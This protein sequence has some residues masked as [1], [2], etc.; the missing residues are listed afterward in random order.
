MIHL[1]PSLRRRRLSLAI[2][3]ST[4]AWV[5][6]SPPAAN[7]QCAPDP[8]TANGTTT[9]A[10]A[11]TDGLVVATPGTQVTV[12]SGATVAP[13]SAAAISIRSTNVQLTVNGA[14]DGV[15]KPGIAVIAGA[16]FT[17]PCDPYAGAG[18]GYCTPG[19]TT[20]YYPSA[21][22]TISVAEGGSV[23]GSQALLVSR[24][25]SNSLGYLSVSVTNAGTMTSASGPAIVATG[26]SSSDLPYLY[27]SN[28]ATGSIGGI[29]GAVS[30]VGNAG[31]ID[32]GSGAAIAGS[33]IFG[34]SVSNT[35][36]IR[37]SGSAATVSSAA[38]LLVTNASGATLG[39]SA[40]A[41]QADGYISLVNAG[42]IIGSVVSNVT[43]GYVSTIDTREGVIDGDVI[44]GAGNDTLRARF[45]AASGRVAS[46]TGTIDGGDGTDTLTIGI[47][48]DATVSRA[49]LPTNFELFGM[50]LAN[51]ATVTL[52]PGFT[53]GVGASFSGHG[54]VINQANL[55]TGGPAVVGTASFSPLSFINDGTIT[56]TLASD[57]EVAVSGLTN[58]TN[59]GT[60]TAIGG[61]GARVGSSL[62][63]NGTITAS[64]IAV[65]TASGSLTNTGTIR[66]TGSTGASISSA[67]ST[68]DGSIIGATTGVDLG[69]GTLVNNGT[70]SGGTTGVALSYSSS[71]TNNAGGTITGGVR[72]A[73][74][75]ARVTNAGTIDGSVEL[76]TNGSFDSSDDVFVD[77][78]GTVLGAI[79]LG[80][81]YDRLVV[82]LVSQE[83]RPLAGATGGVDGGDGFD[84]VHYRVNADASAALALVSGFEWLAYELDN[85]AALT[86]TAA[87]PITM[88]LGLTGNG[89]VTLAGTLS[90]SDRTLVD[91]TILTAAQLTGGG[92][93]P[94]QALSIVNNGTLNLSTAGPYGSNAVA[95][96]N[97]GTADVTNNGT[98]AVTNAAGIYYPAS[99]IFNG[100]AVT[101]TGAITLSG[102]GTAIN[103]ARTLVNSGTITGVAG[104]DIIG[105]FN[106]GSLDNSGTIQVDGTAVQMAYAPGDIVNSG[107]IESRQGTAVGLSYASVLTNEAGGTIRGVT[108][109]GLT[110]GGSVVNRGAIIGDIAANAYSYSGASYIADGGTLT[111]NLTFGSGSDLFLTTGAENGVSGTI[112]GGSGLDAFGRVLTSSGAVALGDDARAVNFEAM[113]IHASGADTVV[114]ITGGGQVTGSL[115]LSGDGTIINTATIDGAVSATQP[116]AARLVLPFYNGIAAFDNQGSIA[117][118]ISGGISDFTNSG[119]L[120][121]AALESAAVQLGGPGSLDFTNG[122][123]IRNAGSVPTVRLDTFRGYAITASNSGTIEGGGLSAGI[124]EFFGVELPSTPSTIALTNSGGIST[125][126]DGATAVNLRVATIYGAGMSLTLNNSGTL[127]AS[128]PAGGGAFLQAYNYSGQGASGTITVANSGTIRANGG[129]VVDSVFTWPTTPPY[130]HTIEIP[131]T[132]PAIALGVAGT[133]GARATITNAATGLIE[134]TGPLSTAIGIFDAALDLTNDGTIH[135]GAGTVL[136]EDDAIGR[137]YLAGA[138]QAIGEA[139]DRI[140]NNGTI[141]GSIDLGAGDDRT[142]NY[143]RIEG[144]VFLGLGD[145][146]FLQRVGATLIGTVDAGEGTDSFI[147]D[148]TGGGSVNGDQFINFERFSQI[149]EGIVTYSGD[150]RLNTIE[151][152]GGTVTVAAGQ[153]L[154]STGPTTVTGSGGSETLRNDGI[155]AGAVA[156]GDGNDQIFNNGTIQG[157]VALDAGDDS[158]VDGPNGG[159]AGTIDGGAGTDRYTFVLAGNR[160]AGNA[161]T[162][163]ERLAVQGTG[164]LTLVSAQDWESIGLTGTGLTLALGGFRVGS[165]TGSDGSEQLQLDGDVGSATLGAGDDTL[166]L[167]ATAAVGRY[168]G[169][170]GSDMLRFTA[171]GPVTLIGSASGFDRI[172]LTGGMLTVAG[173]LGTA[174]DAIGFDVGDQQLFLASSGTITGIVDLGAGNDSFSFAANGAL[175]GTLSGGAGTD[176]ATLQLAGDRTLVSGVL[177]DFEVLQ[178]EGAGQ[179]LLR[180]AH[181]FERVALDADLTILADGALGAGQVQFGAG[182]NRLTILGQFIG[183]VDGGAGSDTLAVSGGSATEQVAFG[184]IANVEAFGMSGGYATISGSALLG[185]LDLT[186]GR[187]VGLSGSTIGAT[188]IFVRQGATFGSAGTVNGNLSVSGILSPG[189]SPGTMT[190]NGNVT[191]AGTSLSLFELGATQSDKLVVN[192]TLSIAP[193]ATLQLAA[194]NM[195]PGRTFDLIVASG[196]ITGSY[197]TILK[198]DSLFGVLVQQADRI[199]LLGEFLNSE[200]FSQQAQRS[201][202][203]VNTV[204]RSGDGSAALLAAVPQLASASGASDVAAF[205]QLAPEAY[206]SASQITVEHGL[207][208]ADAGRSDAFAPRRDTPGGFTFAS[209]L[210]NFRTLE[211]G[212]QGTVRTQTNDY[213]FLGGIGWGSDAWSV[214]AFLGYLN[215]R[216]T[217]AGRAERTEADGFVAGVHGRWTSGGLGLKATIAYDRSDATTRRVLP[218]GSAKGDY[219]LQGWTAD[220]SVDYAMPLSGNW[221]VRPSLGATA[222]RATRNALRESGGSAFALDVARE[223][224]D[225][226]F[227][228]GGL[229]LRGGTDQGAKARPYLSIGARYQAV[230]RVPFALGAMGGGEYGLLAAGASRASVLATATL[231]GDVALSQRVLLFGVL[232]GESGDSDYRASARAGLRLSF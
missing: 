111:G 45:D 38:D 174:G 171:G 27:V 204:L 184:N 29:S 150:F 19:S 163:F 109:V 56:A 220:A 39:G 94:D 1:A 197:T 198:P 121:S 125:A 205:A 101:N 222:I 9:C 160:N 170:A 216:Q 112:D 110:S 203:Y 188:N 20:T 79:D 103:N 207:G 146:T 91:S 202:G 68:N 190:I 212:A 128:G 81:G 12:E 131:Y 34:I 178:G 17:G 175:N 214:G 117:S 108:A 158:F 149:G 80:G 189:A 192:G 113:F 58:L 83:G 84:T 75:S 100:D 129:G 215:S 31:V 162:G 73:G 133:P 70:I 44:L 105:I 155:V 23:N 24:D 180:G 11:D 96:I 25:P 59:N 122:G 201:I 186:G 219:D 182:D 221:V 225:A 40:I 98:I 138:I 226:V 166:G 185:S 211:D 230:G 213:G 65:V 54:T 64:A 143:G 227:V 153:T 167:G 191:L 199:L 57:Y 69:S 16:A 195:M 76:S 72:N 196:G 194:E 176:T 127:E 74:W 77:A 53:S 85:G 10:G 183:S 130:D 107:V 106:V 118:G 41:L 5:L 126:V 173:T 82:D 148:A 71:L 48:S 99:A 136:A 14:I 4:L 169:G 18:V 6:A 223:R 137:P 36:Q 144:D 55:V 42:T 78:G 123:E 218:S 179:L 92:A 35:G 168:L 86:L 120:G 115:F 132:N 141:I 2:G 159:V 147:V 67:V 177:T 231:G 33:G 63:N 43:I 61:K 145:D 46:I 193:G 161:G 22:A 88:A 28:L 50:D 165:A 104:S 102:G 210:A 21:S 164:T 172:A 8:T 95:A 209:G 51:N 152:S 13:G 32:G 116:Y 208:L 228:D 187:L 49:L 229:T 7:A 47:D 52:A 114:T 124:G 134:A 181:G 217:L 135:G 140:V 3:T 206:A 26:A 37:S 154:S 156:L 66:S 97:A 224:T 232:R 89:T 15:A 142:E 157:A 200:A 90:S 87:T 60:I 62:V 139:N 30:S 151:V 119:T 93:G